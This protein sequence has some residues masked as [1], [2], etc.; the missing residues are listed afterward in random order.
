MLLR[1]GTMMKK[2]K[3]LEFCVQIILCMILCFM[4]AGC[5]V[6]DKALV[7][8]LEES[9]TVQEQPVNEDD[10]VQISV[11]CVYVCGAVVSPGVVE[12]PAGSRV[13]DALS[14]V[15]GFTVEAGEDYVNLAARIEDG[16]KIYFPTKAEVQTWEAEQYRKENG[17]VNINTAD[18]NGLMTLPGIGEARAED[19]IAYRKSHGAFRR[20]EDLKNVSG[21]KDNMYEKLVDKI[22]VE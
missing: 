12:L 7:L 21:I 20:K 3:R 4:M 6:P 15:G 17:I 16:Q 5:G 11:I 19:I 10:V 22:V 13:A 2:R 8:S 1:K 14:A 18:K 9:E